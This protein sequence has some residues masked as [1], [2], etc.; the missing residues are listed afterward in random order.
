MANVVGQVGCVTGLVAI[1][2]IAIAFGAGWYLD[3]LMGNERRIATILFLLG[4]FPV[5]LFAMI[6]IS[7]FLVGRAQK[8]VET[9]MASDQNS[10]EKE[11]TQI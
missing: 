7:L 1:G 2:I 9:I 6:R 11:S 10:Q 5:T 8:Q 3:N 4:S